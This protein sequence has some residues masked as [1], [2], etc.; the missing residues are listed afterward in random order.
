MGDLDGWYEADVPLG[1]GSILLDTPIAFLDPKSES[2]SGAV[3]TRNASLIVLTQTCD[4]QKKSQVFVA[5]AEIEPF[6]RIVK[7]NSGM[8]STENRR[9]LARG[10]SV[11]TFLLPPTELGSMGWAVVN[12]RMVHA[13]PKSHAEAHDTGLSVATPYREHLS[14]AY[15]RFMMRVGL[16]SPLEDAFM[17]YIPGS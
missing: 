1:Q 14:Q 12:F 15:A 13:L 10:L 6:D 11:S 2:G 16:P 8:N 7:A 9:S 5:V 4:L 3:L 17:E